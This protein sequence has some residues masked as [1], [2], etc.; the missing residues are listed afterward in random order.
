MAGVNN[1]KIEPEDELL[2][3]QLSHLI[4]QSQNQ[5]AS[6]ANITLTMLFWQIG[7]QINET[8]LQNKRAEYG[9]KIVVALSRQLEE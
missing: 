1:K 7:T 9:K 8:I 2:F 4:G 5:L 6:Q 3:N